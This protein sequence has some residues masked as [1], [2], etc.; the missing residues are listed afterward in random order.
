MLATKDVARLLDMTAI[1]ARRWRARRRLP[2]SEK[3][4]SGRRAAWVIPERALDQF[5]M[6]GPGRPKRCQPEV[7]FSADSAPPCAS[8]RRVGS[9]YIP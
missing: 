4:G 5:R 6:P 7:E 9:L 1:T 2:G 3:I 8:A